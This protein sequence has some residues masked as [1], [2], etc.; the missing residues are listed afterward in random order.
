MGWMLVSPQNSYIGLNAMV[1]GGEACG[2]WLDH[3][4]ST[5]LNGINALIKDI[6][7]NSLSPSTIP[8]HSKKTVI[9][10]LGGGSSPDSKSAELDLRLPSLKNC[11][12]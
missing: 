7:E 8:G 9:Y 3:E 11:E 12:K 2:R 1:L 5:L 10:E 4:G 6:S